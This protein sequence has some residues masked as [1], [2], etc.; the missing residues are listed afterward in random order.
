MELIMK[1]I[2]ALILVLGKGSNQ[3]LVICH[4]SLVTNSQFCFELCTDAI[5]RVSTEL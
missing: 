1:E 2:V 5:Y 4:W 3:S